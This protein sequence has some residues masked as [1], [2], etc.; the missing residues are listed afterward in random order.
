MQEGRRLWAGRPELLRVGFEGKISVLNSIAADRSREIFVSQ[1]GWERRLGV[2][3]CNGSSNLLKVHRLKRE[4]G[5]CWWWWWVVLVI[6]EVE[7]GN[8]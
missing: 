3:C 6:W 1:L 4:D 8:H 2:Q 7:V 5:G